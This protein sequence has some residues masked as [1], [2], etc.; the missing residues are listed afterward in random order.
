MQIAS[1]GPAG[2]AAPRTR[3]SGPAHA[4]APAPARA[5][6][7]G[8]V[9]AVVPA[10]DAAKRGGLRIGDDGLNRRLAGAQATL[11]FLDELDGGLRRFA[12]RVDEAL[13]DGADDP[14]RAEESRLQ[15]DAIWRRRRAASGGSLGPRL[16]YTA[17][18]AQQRFTLPGAD[19]RALRTGAAETLQFS[20]AGTPRQ[21]LP[22]VVEP[23]L[24]PEALVR[25]FDHAFAASG[26]RVAHDGDAL[27]FS[28]S[29]AQW[30]AVR[31]SLA[32]RGGG[33]RFPTG[34]FHRVHPAAE[35]DALPLDGWSVENASASRRTRQQVRGALELVQRARSEA[36]RAL[37]DAGRELERQGAAGDGAWAASFALRFEQWGSDPGF[38]SFRSVA[39]GLS[40]VQRDRVTSLLAAH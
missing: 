12:A 38:R 8:A 39:G 7:A 26:I 31:D 24:A 18:P 16:D 11:R 13:A 40:G 28:V 19:L 35:P 5:A 1:I 23:G 27:V 36:G 20:L 9:D 29:E 6:A 3:A 25:R 30:P 34:Q 15:L 4:P 14:G 37:A 17:A 22:V 10:A 32:V 21:P 33:I 2:I